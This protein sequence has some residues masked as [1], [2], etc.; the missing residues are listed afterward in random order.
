MSWFDPTF[1]NPL[2]RFLVD[3]TEPILGPIRRFMPGGMTIDF[4]PI[5]AIV[6]L[7]ILQAML[8]PH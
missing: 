7:N 5:V 2:G 4:S 3:I 6:L 8:P 1:R